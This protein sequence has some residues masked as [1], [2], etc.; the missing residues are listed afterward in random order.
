VNAAPLRVLV[1]DDDQEDFLILR[2][3]LADYPIGRYELSWVPTLADGVA[4][5]RASQ[6]DV[7]LVDYLLGPDNGL[8][9][10]RLAVAEGSTHRPVILLTGHGSLDVDREALAAGAADYLIKGNID[11]E[12]LA[13]SIRYAAER[14]RQLAEIEDTKQRYRQLFERNPTPTWVYDVGNLRFLA[15]NDAMV[16]NYG[17]AREELLG[18]LRITDIRPED[19]LPRLHAYLERRNDQEGAA[20]IWQHRRKDGSLLW[21]EVTSHPML[22]DGRPCRIVIANDITARREAQA[23]MLLLER[24]VESSTSGVVI[25]D[26]QAGDYPIIYVNAAFERITGYHRRELLGRNCRFLQGDE[27]DQAELDVIR[28]ALRHERDCNVVLRN[29]RRDGS[30]F[31]NHLYLSPVR[32]ERGLV[33]HYVGLQNDLTERRRVDAELAHA[34]SHDAVTDLP[35]YPVLEAQSA[36]L[37]QDGDASLTVYFID[38]DHFHGINETMGHGFGD[39]ALRVLAQRLRDALA[40]AGQV[41]RFAGDEFVAIAADLPPSQRLTLGQ[42]LR[43]AVS[44][45]I[46]GDG[47]RLTL[48]ASIGISHS[49]EHGDTIVELLRRAEAAMTR[50][51]RQGRDALC[52]FSPGQMQQIEDRLLL[53]ARLREAPRRHELTLHYQPLVCTRTQGI[54]GFEAL[55]RWTDAELGAVSPNRFIPIAESLG[56][57][58]EIGQ[59]VF[60]EVCR[61]LRAW[62]DA[63]HVDFFVSVN[64]S[65]QELQRPEVATM[66]RDTVGRHG[67]DPT[68]L[69]IEITESSLMEHVDRVA[70]IMAD[71]KALGLRLSLDDFGTGYSSLSYLKQFALDKLKIDRSFVSELPDNRDDAAIARTIVAIGHQLRMSVVAEG[72]ESPAQAAFLRE[73]G[74]DQLQGYLFGTP[75]PAEQVPALLSRHGRPP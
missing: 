1:V 10:V 8:E 17:F 47:Y 71:M 2:D 57:M 6:H 49:P 67:A 34:A 46:E 3:L 41:A 39:E 60:N 54:A 21:V 9:L 55:L 15:V 48:S 65:A 58:A 50:A 12:K 7:Y 43:A 4:A 5:L 31:W 19:E 33:T 29:F 20:G 66:L 14:S 38:I 45:P 51:K 53:G 16:Q 18:G 28:H 59:W 42:H 70:A 27:R 11:A 25:A 26:A 62:Q 75:V 74:C 69:E 68:R 61:Q 32:D 64:L 24:V 56:L 52:I 35:R 72:V 36:R 44:T 63:G 23:Q 37:L 73:I 40:E 30:L 22:F 13:R